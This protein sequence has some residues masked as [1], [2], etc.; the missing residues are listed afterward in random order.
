MRIYDDIF[1]WEGFGGIYQLASG[2]CRLQI[3]DMRKGH[4]SNV[5]MIKPFLV[6]VSDVID[7]DLDPKKMSVRSCA[8]HIATRITEQFQ[9]DPQRMIYIEFAR[10]SIYGAHGEHRIPAKFESVDFTWRDGK[11]LHPRWRPLEPSL[12]KMIVG[13]MEPVGEY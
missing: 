8:G 7:A 12:K 2:Q 10:E 4:G 6:V 1:T 11:A 5:A 3:Y 13:L 9:I